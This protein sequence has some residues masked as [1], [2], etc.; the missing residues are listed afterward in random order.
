MLRD[1]AGQRGIRIEFEFHRS[2]LISLE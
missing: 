1:I 2:P